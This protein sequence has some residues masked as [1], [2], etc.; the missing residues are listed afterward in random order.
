MRIGSIRFHT[1]RQGVF[2]LLEVDRSEAEKT[3][4][5]LL[6]EGYVFWESDPK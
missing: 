5:W 1:Y 3:R 6:S 2:Q 4:L